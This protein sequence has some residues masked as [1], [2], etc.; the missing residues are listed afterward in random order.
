[1][2]ELLQL[3]VLGV[4]M[5]GVY[6]LIA[7]GFV[8]IHNVTGVINFAQGEFAM[9]GAMLAVGVVARGGGLPL[10][11]LVGAG[12]A[13]VVGWALY[14]GALVPARRASD[15]VLIII[16]IGASIALRGLALVAWGS[17]PVTLPP[18]TAGGPIAFFGAVVS[19]QWMR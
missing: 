6:A 19:R 4:A 1:M 17:Q 15:V 9:V 7:V 11:T 8:I 12:G 3:V 16:T 14:R 2:L 5:G 13:A 10:A 18:F